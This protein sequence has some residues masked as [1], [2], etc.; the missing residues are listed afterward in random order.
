MF[1]KIEGSVSANGKALQIEDGKL[2]G[3]TLTF[4]TRL[5]PAGT[6]R[7]EFSGRII[8][9][10]IEGTVRTVRADAASQQTWRAV[11]TEVWEPRHFS[12]PAPTLIPPQPQ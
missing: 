9:H 4:V 12:L 10:A 5:D 3:E 11:R 7:Q 8:N 2:V 1:Q 6:T